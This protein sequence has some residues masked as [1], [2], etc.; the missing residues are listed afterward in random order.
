MSMSAANYDVISGV[1][2][3][4]HKARYGTLENYGMKVLWSIHTAL[5]AGTLHLFSVF[6]PARMKT[7]SNSSAIHIPRSKLLG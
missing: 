7:E 1:L 4:D 3:Y 5:H 2:A 6:V